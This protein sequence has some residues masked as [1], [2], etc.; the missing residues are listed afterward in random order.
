MGLIQRAIEGE[1]ISTVGVTIVRK[2]TER[3][4]PPRSVYVNFPMGRPM[5]RAR[6]DKTQRAVLLAALDALHSIKEPGAIQDL[7]IEW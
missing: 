6:D 1:G 5:G 3:I 4:M 2:F 7:S